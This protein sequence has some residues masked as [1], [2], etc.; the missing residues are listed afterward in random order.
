MEVPDRWVKLHQS[1]TQ[2]IKEKFKKERGG[3]WIWRRMFQEIRSTARRRDWRGHSS[4]SAEIV[5]RKGP[6]SCHFIKSQ[7]DSLTFDKN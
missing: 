4:S 7:R 5:T 1:Q 6:S 3:L 2:Q